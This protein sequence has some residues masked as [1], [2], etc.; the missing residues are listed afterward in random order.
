MSDQLDKENRA[1]NG[2]GEGLAADGPVSVNKSVAEQQ[3]IER[4]QSEIQRAG[5]LHWFH[6]LVVVSSLVLTLGVWQYSRAQLQTKIESRFERDAE[7]A[8][9]LIA[10]RLVK[11]EDA[12]WSGAAT[13]RSHGGSMSLAEWRLFA[14]SLRLVDKYPGINGI[15]VILPV[16]RSDGESFIAAQQ[17]EQ[18]GFTI[19]PKHSNSEL[20]PITYIV[21]TAENI[22]AVGLD[23]AHET[24]RYTA[25][26]RARD[27]REAQITGPIVLVQDAEQTPGFLFYVPY[28][29]YDSTTPQFAGLVYAPFVVKELMAGTLEKSRRQVGITL[30]DGGELMFDESVPTDPD[31]DAKPLL[32]RHYSRAMY[33][34]DWEFEVQTTKSF[35][36]AVASSQPSIIL[37]TGLLL[38]ALLL[39]L[40]LLLTRANR[41]AI[42]FAQRMSQGYADKGVALQRSV[43]KLEASN[44]ELA[45]FAFVASHDLQE[46]LRTLNNYAGLLSKEL[47]STEQSQI[48]QDSLRFINSASDRMR[49][50]VVGLLSYSSIGQQP[51]LSVVDCNVLVD[52]VLAGLKDAIDKKQA[53]ITVGELPTVNGYETE[54][55]TL[56][57]NLISNALKFSR[58]DVVTEIEVVGEVGSGQF[59]NRWH[60]QVRDNGLGIPPEAVNQ[61]FK[62]FKRL[63]TREAIEGSGI[64]LANCRKIAALHGGQI[65]V[66]SQ[67]GEGCVFHFT[68]PI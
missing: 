66:E 54:L 36:A 45:Q 53:K 51:S 24:N 1:D 26:L 63:H 34:R 11:Y 33:G 57:Q 64:G 31:Y 56:F 19:H 20:M 8:V 58:P 27:S 4:E 18:P 17:A 39:G 21:P 28:Y 46:P 52:E 41:R 62:I 22:R 13:M 44:E 35:R 7:Q 25:A 61:V 65:W 12:L 60:F 16:S 55:H 59:A 2:S 50:L 37:A 38:D 48:V 14:D 40:F 42:R 30:R 67:P 10:E 9:S 43:D 3:E 6:W 49:K 23:M 68:I 32:T 29:H 15:G 47:G 5:S